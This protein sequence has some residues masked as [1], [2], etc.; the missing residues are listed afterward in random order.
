MGRVQIREENTEI[1]RKVSKGGILRSWFSS[2]AIQVILSLFFLLLYK[3]VTAEVKLGYKNP[4]LEKMATSTI[5]L[6]ALKKSKHLIWQKYKYVINQG[7]QKMSPPF[8]P[9]LFPN[10]AKF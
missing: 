3:K 7:F 1:I 5:K 2:L 9:P 4:K 8:L 10:L 6:K